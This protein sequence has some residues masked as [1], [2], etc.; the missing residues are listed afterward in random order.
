MFSLEDPRILFFEKQ[1]PC[2][3]AKPITYQV[4]QHRSNHDE[5]NDNHPLI[6][7]YVGIV[8]NTIPEQLIGKFIHIYAGSEQ[9]GITGEKEANKQAGLCK[10]DQEEK[11]KTTVVN[12]PI[13]KSVNKST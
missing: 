7:R 5:Y 3:L 1:G 11:I 2:F 4:A 10:N 6:Y 13:D 9:Q 8:R 12:D